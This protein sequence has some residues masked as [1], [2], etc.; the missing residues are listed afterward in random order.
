MLVDSPVDRLRAYL[1]NDS[2]PLLAELDQHSAIANSILHG[3]FH[4]ATQDALE[5]TLRAAV[6]AAQAHR[7]RTFGKGPYLL[8]ER[9][10][11][12]GDFDATHV[13]EYADF[14]V[15]MNGDSVKV[16]NGITET[17]ADAVIASLAL[18]AVQLLS[19]RIA[20]Q[21]LIFV[22]EDGRSVHTFTLTMSGSAYVSSPIQAA[23]LPDI[24]TRF[25]RLASDTL[26]RRVTALLVA[27]L[28]VD[29][30]PLRA[31]LNAWSALEIL[32]SKLFPL[33]EERFFRPIAA[34]DATAAQ[35]TYV[36]R[37]REV[38]SDKYRLTDKFALVSSRLSPEASDQDVPAFKTVKQQRDDLLHGKDI[39]EGA[40]K[41]RE[42]QHL[43][44]KYLGR[45]LKESFALQAP[46]A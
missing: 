28:G 24:P 30:D 10:G 32:V 8:L 19:V 11:I 29:A 5:A 34:A 15:C 13:V 14:A 43:V 39:D 45:H 18:A 37:I 44:R 1:S 33:Y 12:V 4:G 35:R 31:F 2:D 3:A 22:R 40:L 41:V 6:A 7:E 20:G 42:A 23:D 16:P 26:F 9:T 46:A 36:A 25:Q 21:A 38:M 27:S 17:L